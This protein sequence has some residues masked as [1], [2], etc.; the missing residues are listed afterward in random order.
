MRNHHAMG[1][2][3]GSK[4]LDNPHMAQQTPDRMR[5]T[6]N[7]SG[8]KA[9]VRLQYGVPEEVSPWTNEKPAGKQT[10]QPSWQY[11]SGRVTIRKQ[12]NTSHKVR[13]LRIAVVVLS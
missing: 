11:M 5:H 12:K 2:F 1:D 13:I 7:W 10:S 8:D 6:N 3:V 9:P 4:F